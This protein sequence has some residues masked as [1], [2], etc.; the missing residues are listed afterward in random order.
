MCEL[1]IR[2]LAAVSLASYI[3]YEVSKIIQNSN[4]ASK[5]IIY[6]TSV[7]NVRLLRFETLTVCL[8]DNA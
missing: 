3:W 8:T 1:M 5:L 7:S 2:R 6:C 4:E